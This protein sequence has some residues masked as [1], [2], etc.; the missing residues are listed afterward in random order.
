MTHLKEKHVSEEMREPDAW[1]VEWQRD[2][3]TWVDAHAD[4]VRAVDQARRY[5]GTCTPLYRSTLREQTP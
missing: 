4:E 5:G 2:G 3:E 1:L